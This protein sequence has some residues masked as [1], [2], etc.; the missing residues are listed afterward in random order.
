MPIIEVPG[1]GQ[2]EFPDD[3]S[4]DQI[5]SAI[6]KNALGYKQESPT[7][8]QRFAQGLKDPIDAGAQLLTHILPDSVVKKGNELNNWLADKTGLVSRL[9]D[10]GVDQQIRETD[11]R[12][13]SDGIDGYRLA[14]NVF[15]PA[16]LAVASRFTPAVTMAGRVGQGIAMGGISGALTPYTGED[17]TQDKLEQIG[18]SAALGGSVPAVTGAIGR[19]I[20]P[21]AS[22]NPDIALLKKEGVTPTIGQTLGGVFN[23]AEEKLQSLPVFGDAISRARGR[24]LGEFNK[25]AINRATNPIGQSIDDIGHDGVKRAGDLL[26]GAYDEAEKLLKYVRLDNQFNSDLGQ[27]RSMAQGLEPK[28]QKQ[29]ERLIQDKIGSRVSNNGSLFADKYKDIVSDI[30]KE[31]GK[32]KGLE[33][34]GARD[35]SSAVLQ[36]Q[37]LLKQQIGRGANPEAADI[38]K[39]ADKGYANLVRVEG[40]A[41]RALKNDGVFTP[42]QLSA[43]VKSADNSVRDRATA[44]GVSLMQDLSRAGENVI[45]NKVPDSGTTGR[46]FMGGG[47]LGASLMTNPAI[48][49]GLAGGFPI[50]SKLGQQLLNASVTARPQLAQPVA[51]GVRNSTPYL[52][53]AVTGLLNY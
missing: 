32:F 3:M 12:F 36:L 45:G 1:H 19:V 39:A 6:K 49:V 21:K 30:G 14:G 10:G 29:F 48:A 13:K 38:M 22:V 27:L 40:A 8:R 28:Y 20:S 17:F 52:V 46:L 50:Y 42:Y 7:N 24:A 44:R 31:A 37:N 11:E 47:A 35:Y 23:S 9:P 18:T 16:N 4:D 53:P 33:N 43:S 41:N 34:S 51:K 2:V 26:G 15:S 25:A 5:V